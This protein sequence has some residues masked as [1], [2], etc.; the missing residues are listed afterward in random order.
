[1]P[2]I[3]IA[4]YMVLIR[5]AISKKSQSYVSTVHGE[6]TDTERANP[7]HYPMKPLEVRISQFMHNDSVPPHEVDDQERQSTC[8]VEYVEEASYSV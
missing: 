8:K 3:S 7:R 4:F 2:I 6:T 5:I 1:M